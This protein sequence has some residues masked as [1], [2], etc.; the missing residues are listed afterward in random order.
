MAFLYGLIYA[1]VFIL[2]SLSLFKVYQLEGY[3]VK[4]FIKKISIKE[5]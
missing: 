4:N 1:I 2:L 5:K 3:K